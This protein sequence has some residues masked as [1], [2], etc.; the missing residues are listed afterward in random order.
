MVEKDESVVNLEKTGEIELPEFDASEYIGKVAKIESVTEHRGSYG[1]YIKVAT[2]NIDEEAA[3]PVIASR[4][5]GLQT[6][7]DDKGEDLIGWGKDTKL[8]LFL[9]KMN[10]SHYK[11]LVGKEV[12]VQTHTSKEG[13]DFLTFN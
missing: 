1:F 13:K 11:E 6:T 7:K 2:E 3:F 9:K 5:F 8:G 12:K 10:V 4:I